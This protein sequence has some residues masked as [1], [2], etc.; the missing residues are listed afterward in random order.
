M[1]QG[2]TFVSKK[3]IKNPWLSIWIKPKKTFAYLLNQYPGYE[4]YFLAIL[5]GS[6]ATIDRAIKKGIGDYAGIIGILIWIFTIGC[7]YGIIGIYLFGGIT[8]LISKKLGGYAT[9]ESLRIVY[10]WS[11]LPAIISYLPLIPILIIF[12][13]TLFLSNT[14]WVSTPIALLFLV[15]G[16]IT[17]PFRV[18]QIVLL[19]IGVREANQF[20]VWH[21][22]RV[23]VISG[24][25][26][27][28]PALLFGFFVFLIL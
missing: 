3:E 27:L 8:S 10:A 22:I 16:L 14:D 26:V 28:I 5:S 20:S 17:V 21:A 2:S 25:I 23:L 12:H 9:G 24:L 18:W 15:I 7:I 4:I 19:V 1:I 13:E 6:L 11:S